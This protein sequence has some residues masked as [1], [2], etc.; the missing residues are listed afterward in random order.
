M[1]TYMVGGGMDKYLDGR[2]G[3]DEYLDGGG[4]MH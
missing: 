1:D 2:G 4:G 3:M